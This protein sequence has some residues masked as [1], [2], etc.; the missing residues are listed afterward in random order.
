[1]QKAIDELKRASPIDGRLFELAR[2]LI[3]STTGA[4]PCVE[5]RFFMTFFSYLPMTK[6][7]SCASFTPRSRAASREWLLPIGSR[8][9]S[10]AGY[11]IITDIKDF[12]QPGSSGQ[13]PRR[14]LS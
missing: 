2:M 6:T 1:V 14:S 5:D 10:P 8:K 3:Y 4:V 7:T 13:S 12:E 11:W 9:D